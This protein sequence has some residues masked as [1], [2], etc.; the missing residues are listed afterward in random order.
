[1]AKPELRQLRV[2]DLIV[3]P[4]IQRSVDRIRA[5]AMATDLDMDAVGVITVSRRT[6]GSYHIIDGQH[7]VEALRLAGGEGEKVHCRIFSNLSVEDEARMFRLLNNSKSLQA[8]DKFRVRVVEGEEVAVFISDVL[9]RYGWKVTPASGEG[10]FTAVVAAERVYHRDYTAVERTIATVTRA[11]GHDSASADGRIIEGLGLVYARYG[12]T[13]DDNDVVE[14]LAKYA[15]GANRLIGNARGIRDI[16][17]ISVASAVADIVV[18]LY[19]QRR[20]TKALA[21][22]RA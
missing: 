12:E 5:G 13:C 10:C 11:W 14:R 3:D 15:G 21:P 19:N 16:Y 9:T 20:K 1:M 22:W 8:L 7:R 18:E 6:N 17:R 4:H 2:S